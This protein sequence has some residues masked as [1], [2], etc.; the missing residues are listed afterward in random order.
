[1]GVQQLPLR[2]NLFSTIDDSL[3]VLAVR[4]RIVA[5]LEIA[6]E[7]FGI[8][9]ELSDQSNFLLFTGE[10]PN[11]IPLLSLTDLAKWTGGTENSSELAGQLPDAVSPSSKNNADA[12]RFKDMS[13]GMLTSGTVT[14]VGLTLGMPDWIII[15][16]TFSVMDAEIHFDVINPFPSDGIERKITVFIRGTIAIGDT[17]FRIVTEMPNFR[18][19]GTL[20]E[21]RPLRVT[22]LAEKLLASAG[23]SFPDD[24]PNFDITDALLEVHPKSGYF[25]LYTRATFDWRIPASDPF[26][27]IRNFRL[28][29][30]RFGKDQIQAFIAG[31]FTLGSTPFVLSAYNPLDNEGWTFQAALD[32]ADSE[33]TPTISLTEVV[34]QFLPEGVTLPESIPDFAFTD[35]RFEITPAAGTFLFTARSA[36]QWDIPIG[37]NGLSLS[38]INFS[39][40]RTEVGG[41]KQVTGTIGG[42][43]NIGDAHFTAT[44]N[45]PGDFVL[46][47]SIPSFKLSVII[48]ELCGPD[49]LNGL[50]VPGGY[51]DVELSNISFYI[52]PQRGQ[53][54]VSGASP[55]GQ[56]ELQIKRMINGEWGFSL[57]Y[58]PPSTWRFS[59]IDSSLSVLDGLNFSN[60][61]LI[62]ASSNDRSF[63]LVT[64]KTPRDNVSVI[65]G[66]N[67]FATLDMSALGVKDLLNIEFLTVY[68]AIG[69]DPKNITL[70]AIIA[71]KFQLAENVFFGD[72]KF[73]LKPSPTDFSLTLL[74]RIDAILGDSTLSFVG[75][76]GIRANPGSFQALLK[77]TMQGTWNE[78]FGAKGVAI[79]DVALELGIAFPPIRPSIGIAGGLQIGEFRG[80]VAVKFDAANPSK[81]MLAIAF[82][83]L[84]LI[85]IFNAFCPPEARN[86]IPMD[87]VKT[88]LDVGFEDVNIYIV[89]QPTSI[90]ELYFEQGISLKATMYL[91]G[92]RAFGYLSID[93][94]RGILV[95]GDMDEI[96]LAGIFKLTG[97]GG[98]PKASLYAD[99]RTGATPTINISGA[100]ELLGLRRETELRISDKE[101][102]FLI[103][104]RI[105]D[106][107]EATLEVKGSTLASGDGIY[108]KATM[109][110][111]LF[112]YLREEATKVIQQTANDAIQKISEAQQSVLEAENKVNQI[113]ADIDAMRRTV[114]SERDRD[115][116]R[117]RSAQNDVQNAQNE[118]NRIQNDINN[119][120]ARI[121]QLKR[122]IDAKHNWYNGLPWWDQAWAWTEVGAYDTAKGAEIA[123]LYTAIGGLETGKHTAIGI[124]EAAKQT[125]RGFELAAVT[126]PVD[127]DPRVAGMFAGREI[128]NGA[129]EA[130]RWTL[131]GVKLSVGAAAEVGEY[132]VRFGLGGLLDIREAMFEA[133]LSAAH[134][135]YISMAVSIMFMDKP[136][137]FAFAFNFKDPLTSAKELANT[138]L[139]A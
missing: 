67:F 21:D 102:Y 79:M 59:Q 78:P 95:Q 2:L 4:M 57:G 83:K 22:A 14:S 124:L 94:T 16:G 87:I 122:D 13:L 131:E 55:L 74:G 123:G 116:G 82:N 8:S 35:V 76:L 119:L 10:A 23:I 115:S 92:L 71:G 44:Y 98:K 138:L 112:A 31:A 110:N 69:S 33:I 15:D 90:G 104:G 51:L 75:G 20:L 28:N 85:D 6:S 5:T 101:F 52:A 27:E 39:I 86:A 89:P 135:G 32:E 12:F 3:K 73:Q 45:F 113:N 125:L 107:F 129:L 61:A 30:E 111:D 91:W 134:G 66:L 97:A 132:I 96:N 64:I 70:E 100:V 117:L 36:S 130:A 53:F 38:D 54:S 126:I 109:R 121:D 114:Q 29:I 37:I 137:S 24:M 17:A 63:D 103:I 50:S 11:G 48:E 7:Q 81:S 46:S 106:L 42:T 99:L 58:V 34:R 26:I 40:N 139:P 133:S 49:A 43:L 47:G 41:K 80:A 77:A 128:A 65:R 1:V 120:N 93:Q 88:V 118:V 127:A 136:Q 68:A 105:F 72:I 56:L 60:T 108:I 25:S 19:F 62:I 9:A 18:V 84:Y